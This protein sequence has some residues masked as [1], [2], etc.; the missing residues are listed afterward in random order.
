MNYNE[1]NLSS[2]ERI[3]LITCIFILACIISRLFFGVWAIGLMGF[4]VIKK[5][6][7]LYKSYRIKQRKKVVLYQFKD[8]LYSFSSSFFSGRHMPEAIKEAIVYLTSIYGEKALLVNELCNMSSSIESAKEDDC[9]LWIT[10]GN[11]SGIED[12][13]NFAEI[14]ACCRETGGD[15]TEVVNRAAKIISD[16]ID[17][18]K[19]IDSM[20]SQRKLEGRMIATMP[21][22]ILLFL[23]LTAADHIK[24]MY[25][26]W[27]GHLI[28]AV[29]I[30]IMAL[31][32]YIIERIVNI[33]I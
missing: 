28:M 23:N 30:A 24:V 2:K 7:A 27:Q 9:I 14:Y 25:V 10:F 6:V 4:L 19:Q 26:T 11:K 5:A 29:L 33:E 13:Q 12:I 20:L 18:E 21:I 22:V 1:Y 3:L 15:L 17:T 32:L 8:C 31:G 16:K